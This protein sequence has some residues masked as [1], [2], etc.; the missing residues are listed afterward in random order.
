MVDHISTA[1]RSDNMSRIRSVNS[2]PEVLVRSLL[3]RLGYR[4]RKNLKTLPGKPDIVLKR[5][6]TII[7]VHGCFWHRHKGCKRSNVP[8]SN[9]DYWEPKLAGNVLRDRKHKASL[10]SLGW[11]VFTVWECETKDITKLSN[12][13]RRI[14]N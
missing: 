14:F 3:H 11:K 1:H 6:N 5:H 4:F 7:F 10:K 9:Q 2:K 13:L 8:K 12:K